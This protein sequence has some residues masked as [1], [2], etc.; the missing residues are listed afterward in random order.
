MWLQER[1]KTFSKSGIGNSIL[2]FPPEHMLAMLFEFRSSAIAEV[3]R[4]RLFCQDFSK[5]NVT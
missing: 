5:I 2:D 1:G 3:F 4:S